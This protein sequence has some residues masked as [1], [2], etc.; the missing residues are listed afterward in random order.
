[1]KTNS[2]LLSRGVTC[3]TTRQ[4][5]FTYRQPAHPPLASTSELSSTNWDMTDWRERD[6]FRNFISHDTEDEVN[7][8]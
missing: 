1:M 2:E 7:P 4:P 3:I 5:T 8:T 6:W